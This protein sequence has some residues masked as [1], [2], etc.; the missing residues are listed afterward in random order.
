MRRW[1]C[2]NSEKTVKT[3][4]I[5]QLFNEKRPRQRPARR[6]RLSLHERHRVERARPSRR[7]LEGERRRDRSISEDD[8][9]RAKLTLRSPGSCCEVKCESRAR[10]SRESVLVDDARCSRLEA[11]TLT[12][13]GR[14]ISDLRSA[15]HALVP[16]VKSARRVGEL[17][18]G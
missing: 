11:A 18:S 1:G 3:R 6:G 17:E 8:E 2:A 10:N 5:T 13:A 7:A 16:V 15:E 14:N 9:K 12:M 4:T